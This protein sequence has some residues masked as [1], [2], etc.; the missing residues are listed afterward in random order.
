M[1][2]LAVLHNSPYNKQFKRIELINMDKLPE[3][4]VLLTIVEKHE[5]VNQ[6]ISESYCIFNDEVYHYKN[7]QYYHKNYMDTI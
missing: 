2:V 7:G 5:G 6:F 1:K 4:R 3:Y